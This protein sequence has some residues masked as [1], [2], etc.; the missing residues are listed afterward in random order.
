MVKIRT[1]SGFYIVIDRKLNLLSCDY[2][3]PIAWN[4]FVS[5]FCDLIVCEFV[6][7]RLKEAT[8]AQS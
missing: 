1:D 5:L 4:T 6:F 8:D 3:Q 7:A 2:S